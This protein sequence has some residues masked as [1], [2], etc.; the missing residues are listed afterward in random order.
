MEHYFAAKT[1]VVRGL[2]LIGH[3]NPTNK[4]G[5][6]S[7]RSIHIMGSVR[8][9]LYSRLH[10]GLVKKIITFFEISP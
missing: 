7:E 6:Y 10:L 5:F 4:Q 8:K 3:P 1:F 2:S 9:K